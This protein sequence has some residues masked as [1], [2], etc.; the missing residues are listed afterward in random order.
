MKDRTVGDIVKKAT[1]I[2]KKC[3]KL[4]KMYIDL[5]QAVNL[6]QCNLGLLEEERREMQHES[7]EWKMDIEK[8]IFNN[9]KKEKR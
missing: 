8:Q 9:L 4:D 6:I 7:D 1:D 3:R 2:Q 5:S